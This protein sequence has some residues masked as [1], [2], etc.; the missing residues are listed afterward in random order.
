MLV[1]PASC[2]IIK[3]FIIVLQVPYKQSKVNTFDT[4]VPKVSLTEEQNRHVNVAGWNLQYKQA[5]LRNT[6]LDHHRATQNFLPEPMQIEERSGQNQ[7]HDLLAV[8]AQHCTTVSPMIFP[9]A[10]F[11]Y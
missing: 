7:T 9:R 10:F 8:K 6:S 11:S 3:H 5:G 4:L 2:S 1:K